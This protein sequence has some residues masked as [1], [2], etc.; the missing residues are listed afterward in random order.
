MKLFLFDGEACN[1][2]VRSAIY[3]DASPQNRRK[4][5]DTKYFSRIQHKKIKGLETLPRFPL[6]AA[7]YDDKPVYAMPGPA[8]AC[9]NSAAQLSSPGKL[10]FF[11]SHAADSSGCLEAG[12]P[13][14]AFSRKDPMSDR[15]CS[16]LSNPMY[17]IPDEEPCLLCM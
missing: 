13:L 3:G 9:K 6:L 7:Y 16:L 15:L 12:L 1:Q 14:P 8:H 11:G 4:I 10:L 2:V 5:F 17:L